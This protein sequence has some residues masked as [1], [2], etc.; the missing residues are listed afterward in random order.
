MYENNL[1][2]A[3]IAISASGNNTVITAPDGG[4]IAIDHIDFIP[5]SAVTVTIKD[6][7]N[8]YVYPLEVKQAF[9]IE[10]AMLNPKG[11]I[12]CKDSTAFIISLSA[13]VTVGGMIRYRIVK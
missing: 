6:G 7:N 5:T 12:T 1:E 9:T 3:A 11:V 2:S 4:Y 10:N 8:E 13:A